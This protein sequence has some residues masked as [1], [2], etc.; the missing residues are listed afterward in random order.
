MTPSSSNGT[1][2]PSQNGRN[3]SKSIIAVSLKGHLRGFELFFQRTKYSIVKHI[4]IRR[5][6]QMNIGGDWRLFAVMRTSVSTKYKPKRATT[7]I[8]KTRSIHQESVLPPN[9]VPSQPTGASTKSLKT[10]MQV[11]MIHV[12]IW[13]IL[14]MRN[15]FNELQQSIHIRR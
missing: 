4:A 2:N 8:S 13:G 6:I 10:F 15:W 7:I 1:K 14:R 9:W 3:D 11:Y 12:P 5:S